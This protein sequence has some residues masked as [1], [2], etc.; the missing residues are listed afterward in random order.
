MMR[1]MNDVFQLGELIDPYLIAHSNDL[2]GNSIFHITNKIFVDVDA[3]ELNDVLSSSG[4]TQVDEDDDSDEINVE[5]CDGN[6]DESINEEED[7][8]YYFAQPN[9]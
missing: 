3:K 1:K 5:D 6:E 9:L 7:N 4:H 8:S 2:E